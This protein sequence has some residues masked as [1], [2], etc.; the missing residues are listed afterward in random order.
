MQ[1]KQSYI[2]KIKIQFYLT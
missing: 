2:Y 1:P